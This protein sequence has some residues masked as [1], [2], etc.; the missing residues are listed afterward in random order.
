M[1]AD[2]FQE[3]ET[4]A[5]EHKILA[6]HGIRS[7]GECSCIYRRQLDHLKDFCP[8]LA[9]DERLLSAGADVAAFLPRT[10]PVS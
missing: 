1:I 5:V 3:T 10:Y 2:D 6:V 7:F 9:G 8:N 4:N